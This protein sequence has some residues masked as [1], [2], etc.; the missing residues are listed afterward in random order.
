MNEVKWNTWESLAVH[1]TPP[2]VLTLG[3]DGCIVFISALSPKEIVMAPKHSLSWRG[4]RIDYQSCGKRRGGAG[5]TFKGCGLDKTAFAKV[6]FYFIIAAT[7]E[8]SLQDVPPYSKETTGLHLNKRR[9]DF[10]TLPNNEVESFT[11]EWGFIPTATVSFNTISEVQSFSSEV[12]KTGKWRSEAVEGFVVRTIISNREPQFVQA[13]RGTRGERVT[14]KK[15]LSTPPPYA[16]GST[17]FFKIKFEEPYLM[18]REWRE[19]TKRMLSVADEGR[20]DGTK[21]S[22]YMLRRPET[23]AYVH[24]VTVQIRGNR[25]SLEG[26]N[27]GHGIIAARERFFAW[28][29]TWEGLEVLERQ[30]ASAPERAEGD[31]GDLHKSVVISVAIPGSGESA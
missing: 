7:T 15:E 18:Y 14:D 6:L 10:Y 28:C 5:Y 1:I 31:H 30:H 23:K 11:R 27:D 9:G 4:R 25:K 16:P 3:S 29:E 21:L 19:A 2:Y 13:Y 12:G 26:Y 20:L 8:V 24:W 17:L 22:S